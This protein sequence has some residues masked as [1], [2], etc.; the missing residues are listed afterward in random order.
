MARVCSM[1]RALTPSRSETRLDN[2]M[3]AS[4]SN[5]SSRFCNC[6]RF[7]VCCSLARVIVRHKR[8]SGS[9]TKLRINSLATNRFSRRSA[10]TK[11]LLRPRRARFDCACARCR[12]PDIGRA[13][14]PF[15]T[16][17]SGPSR[18]DWVSRHLR[19]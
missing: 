7:R 10:S 9:G 12:V 17:G 5:A 6:T 4:S 18:A 2:L 8:C 14:S 1:R 3:C 19:P 11:S 15:W 13:P 16:I